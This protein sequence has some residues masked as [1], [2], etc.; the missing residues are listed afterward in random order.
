MRRNAKKTKNTFAKTDNRGKATSVRSIQE[1]DNSDDE[2][3][4]STQPSTAA[5]V[6]GDLCRSLIKTHKQKLRENVTE[7]C[8]HLQYQGSQTCKPH[9]SDIV[10]YMKFNK[11]TKKDTESNTPVQEPSRSFSSKPSQKPSDRVDPLRNCYSTARS[12]GLWDNDSV[13]SNQTELNLW[14]YVAFW[15]TKK[16]TNKG[17][18]NRW[19]N[20]NAKR[21]TPEFCERGTVL[22]TEWLKAW[23]C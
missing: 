2:L 12:E 15:R 18:E 1:I 4:L 14:K 5:V 22:E 13:A 11:M 23:R 17:N 3:L 9:T 10:K 7:K 6:E 21:P 8:S 19:T 20:E 16:G